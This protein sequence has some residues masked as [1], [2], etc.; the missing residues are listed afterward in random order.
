MTWLLDILE[1]YGLNE[2]ETTYADESPGEGRITH[3]GRPDPPEFI[4]QVDGSAD[5]RWVDEVRWR[6]K[7][8]EL[9][10]RDLH[11][12]LHQIDARLYGAM[13]ETWKKTDI[14]ITDP[15]PSIR[16]VSDDWV[17]LIGL[18]DFAQCMKVPG[19]IETIK[20]RAA[21]DLLGETP[22]F[23]LGWLA[24]MSRPTLC[25]PDTGVELPIWSDRTRWHERLNGKLRRA[26][27]F[28]GR[29]N[30][31]NWG[32][33]DDD[34]FAEAIQQT[35]EETLVFFRHPNCA[36][37]L[38]TEH[39]VCRIF[40]AGHDKAVAHVRRV[41]SESLNAVVDYCCL[42][43]PDSFGQIDNRPS[44]SSDHL[45]AADLAAGFAREAYQQA[46]IP[47]VLRKLRAVLYNGKVIR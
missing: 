42:A 43:L 19:F 22:L 25:L 40:D 31:A 34:H 14:I 47:G 33:C 12:W 45:Q 29:L 15:R 7:L 9:K 18:K 26:L 3:G 16:R 5:L 32:L 28:A 23:R 46:G 1:Q 10:Y 17:E 8:T 20:E 2:P 38:L 37:V 39:A 11:S 27:E 35:E 13:E 36:R 44:E 30:A 41:R 21:L 24:T 6:T 4:A